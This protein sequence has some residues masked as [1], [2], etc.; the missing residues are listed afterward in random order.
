MIRFSCS[1]HGRHVEGNTIPSFIEAVRMGCDVIEFDVLTTLDGVVMCHHDP[2]IEETGEN[3]K[4]TWFTM[5]CCGRPL[6]GRQALSIT[7]CW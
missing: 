6:M 2:L 5:C 7:V 3:L 4:R 1:R